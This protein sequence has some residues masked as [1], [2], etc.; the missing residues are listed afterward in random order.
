MG[1]A[2]SSTSTAG[3]KLLA[4]AKHALSQFVL[5]EDLTLPLFGD[6]HKDE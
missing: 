1:I 5:K 4:V 2:K 3:L 6:N